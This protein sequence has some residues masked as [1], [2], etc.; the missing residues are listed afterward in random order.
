[1]GKDDKNIFLGKQGQVVGPISQA[2]LETLQASG[3]IA[4]YT[5]LWD[6]TGFC[7]R[8][9]EAPPPPPPGMEQAAKKAERARAAA[10]L[11]MKDKIL[12]LPSWADMEAICHNFSHVI[13]G[14]IKNV[15]ESGC[16]LV[17]H[18]PSDLPRMGISS[19]LL[20]NV[21]DSKK[22]EAMT[23]KASLEEVYREDGAW[24]YRL[25]WETRPTF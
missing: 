24:V 18:D 5:Y 17:A 13:A 15:T 6:T 2:E 10:A 21:I 7:W 8:P 23:V 3:E 20:L 4:Q 11:P 1:M 22:D 12:P 16:D 19:K 25:A 14:Q 9:L